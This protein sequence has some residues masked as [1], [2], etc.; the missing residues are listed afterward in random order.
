MYIHGKGVARDREKARKMLLQTA[1]EN[2][3][4][5]FLSLG[6]LYRDGLGVKASFV[7]SYMWY[8]LALEAG[9]QSASEK[10]SWLGAKLSRSNI[11]QARVMATQCAKAGYKNCI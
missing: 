11:E 3:P 7:T 2:D 9:E 10:L 8:T 4:H 1:A 5:A 6:E